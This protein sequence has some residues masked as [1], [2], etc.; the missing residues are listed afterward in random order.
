MHAF[1]CISQGNIDHFRYADGTT[2]TL[3]QYP[4]ECF[5]VIRLGEFHCELHRKSRLAMLRDIEAVIGQPHM[6]R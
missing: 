2:V 6:A 4:D 3:A 5:A 1:V